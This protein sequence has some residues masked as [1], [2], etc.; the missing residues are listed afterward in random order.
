MK[1]LVVFIGLLAAAHVSAP[2]AAQTY[3]TKPVTILVP[4]AAGGPADALA[5]V[6]AERGD[7]WVRR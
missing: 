4:F 2:A 3:P 5:R 7:R 1:K 6:V